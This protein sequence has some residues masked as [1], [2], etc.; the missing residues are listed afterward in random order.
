MSAFSSH[1][2]CE[3]YSDGVDVGIGGGDSFERWYDYIL[4]AE[5]SRSR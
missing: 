1:D 4:L 3:L 2:E 5:G